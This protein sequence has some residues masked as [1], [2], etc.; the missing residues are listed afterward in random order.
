M[1]QFIA[2]WGKFDDEN[3]R[4]FHRLEHHC[5]DV[6]A[7]FEALV[8]EPVV[9][10]RFARAAGVYEKLDEV[11]ISRLTVLAF[12]HDFAK[13]NAGFQFKVFD[14]ENLPPHPPRPAGHVSEAYFAV[15]QKEICEALGFFEF[16]ESWGKGINDLLCAALAHHGRPALKKGDGSGPSEL[17]KTYSG[18]NPL[19]TAK[20]LRDRIREWFPQALEAGP[21]LPTCRALAHLF[22]GTVAL[23]DQIGSD[24]ENHFPFQ[25]EI[26]PNYIDRARSQA[27]KALQARGLKRASWRDQ[28]YCPDF[29]TMFG[30]ARPR[31]IQQELMN[32]PLDDSLLIL[33]SET[34][35]GKTE[36]AVLRFVALWRAGLVDGLYF[37]VP[38][39]AAAKQ[40]H[41]RI[42]RAISKLLPGKW[43]KQTVLAIPGYHVVGEAEGRPAGRFEVFWEDK[44]DEADRIARWSAESTRHFLSSPVAV[45]TIDQALLGALKVKWAHLRGASLSRSLL[46]VDEVHASDAYMN[47]ILR[48]LLAAHLEVGGHALLMSATLG[49]SARTTFTK[50]QIRAD[51]LDLAEAKETPYPSLTLAGNGTSRTIEMRVTGKSKKLDIETKPWLANPKRIA[52]HVRCAAKLGAKVLIVRNTVRGAQ[53][54]YDELWQSDVRHLL[55]SIEGIATLHHSRFAAEDRIRLDN[56]VVATLGKESSPGGCIVIGTQTLEQSLDIDADFLV[57]DLCPVDVLLQRIGRLHR[58]DRSR[59]PKFDKP[60]CIVLIPDGGLEQGLNGS[61]MRHGLGTSSRGGGIYRDLLGVEQTRRLIEEKRNWSIPDMNRELVESATNPIALRSLA[62]N[63]GGPWQE[64]EQR[65]YGFSAAETRT[66]CRHALDRTSPFNEDLRFPDL[67]EKVRT[68]L[69][70]DGPRIVL[71]AEAEGP[72]GL[73]VKTFNLPVHLFGKGQPIPDRDEIESATLTDPPK[74]ILKVGSHCF[75][76]DRSGIRPVGTADA[77][78]GEAGG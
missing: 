43:G 46:V 50:K 61:L 33:E 74:V 41:K 58:H 59:P 22:A 1:Q 28:T 12:L 66:A 62:E 38:T 65:T 17:W 55:L 44:P 23:A 64:H 51:E 32:A 52:E 26:E 47:E 45:G 68:R 15:Q 49:S 8:S 10:A 30:H 63:L 76:Y 25:P 57:T 14:R 27:C 4:G 48:N 13:L 34:G 71:S 24:E 78:S 77:I 56:K 75:H 73:P 3:P 18:Y 6:A 5:A 70:E 53:A 35:S 40:L 60:R 16:Y 11:T 37:A 39:R 69:G 42:D 20:L 29:Q 2:A 67:D 54:L 31:P 21:K 19:D 36:A 7:C 72:F 9:A